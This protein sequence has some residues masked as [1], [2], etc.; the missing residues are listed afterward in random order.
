MFE[1]PERHRMPGQGPAPVRKASEPPARDRTPTSPTSSLDSLFDMPAPRPPAAP[2]APEPPA[3]G[4]QPAPA[5]AQK[6]EPA[7]D[8][9]P[10]Q[11]P[12]TVRAMFELLE[13]DRRGGTLFVRSGRLTLGFELV[14]GCITQ[15]ASDHMLA[16]E[17]LGDLLVELGSCTRE[18]MAAAV[19]KA[20][21]DQ[22]RPLG[23]TLVR[24][25]TV[26]NRQII[27]ALELQVQRRVVRACAL[28]GAEFEFTEG[29]VLPGD[30]RV[31]VAPSAMLRG[32]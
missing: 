15:T 22:D 3:R 24:E 19:V 9:A 14:A 21:T 17:R 8:H 29:E 16:N 18:R 5:P 20:N 2:K 11:T 26:S 32:K 13:R 7:R 6:A 23:E 27:E 10:L 30:G 1:S 4:R 31:Q 28:Q 12:A 25:G